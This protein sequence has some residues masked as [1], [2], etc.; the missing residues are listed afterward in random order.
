MQEADQNLLVAVCCVQMMPLVLTG[1]LGQR[2]VH[3]LWCC[4]SG[5]LPAWIGW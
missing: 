2:A 3:W 1:Q 4:S 5:C